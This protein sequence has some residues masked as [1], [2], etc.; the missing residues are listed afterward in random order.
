MKLWSCWDGHFTQPHFFLGSCCGIS[1]GRGGEYSDILVLFVGADHFWEVQN[2][3]F[4]YFL[5]FSRKENESFW[6]GGGLKN[7]LISFEGNYKICYFGG[8]LYTCFSKPRYRMGMFL[9]DHKI[10]RVFFLGGGGGM[11][12]IPSFGGWG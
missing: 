2:F 6:R 8:H 9:G 10:S 7:L 12:D 1:R 4:Q 3:K 11:P 5:G